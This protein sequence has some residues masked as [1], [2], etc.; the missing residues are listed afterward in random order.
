MQANIEKY[1]TTNVEIHYKLQYQQ[2]HAQLL[3]L[4]KSSQS[5][6]LYNINWILCEQHIHI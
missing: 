5:P 4:L 6:Y 1:C 3:N 2:N